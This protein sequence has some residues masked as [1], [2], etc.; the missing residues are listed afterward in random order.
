MCLCAWLRTHE[1]GGEYGGTSTGH[2]HSDVSRTC[3]SS[4]L[5]AQPSPVPPLQVSPLRN[6]GI[7]HS[8]AYCSTSN[9]RFL[10]MTSVHTC[11]RTASHLNNDGSGG[12]TYMERDIPDDT[13]VC[14]SHVSAVSRSGS[15]SLY[16]ASSMSPD[17][18]LRN[19]FAGSVQRRRPHTTSPASS[20]HKLGKVGPK[21]RRTVPIR[22]L[23]A[24]SEAS[25]T[26]IPVGPTRQSL[27]LQGF[28]ESSGER[29]ERVSMQLQLFS[30]ILQKYVV[31]RSEDSSGKQVLK[32]VRQFLSPAQASNEHA[33]LVHY[34]DSNWLTKILTVTKPWHK[35]LTTF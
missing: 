8:D 2:T 20:P 34:M 18:P 16:A 14:N 1:G 31:H 13:G 22:K 4:S 23:S 26:P 19:V 7:G 21:R 28:Q 9:D 25:E 30:Y 6:R 35:L 12:V 27:T 29:E 10:S 24:V 3:T 33:S 15:E 17:N 32:D 11:T 5:Q